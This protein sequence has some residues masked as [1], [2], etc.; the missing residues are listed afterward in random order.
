M[1]GMGFFRDA[2]ALKLPRGLSSSVV[3]H[4]ATHAPVGN[5]TKPAGSISQTCRISFLCSI[6]ALSSWGR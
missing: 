2:V 4:Q 1:D 6:G 3:C 5:F